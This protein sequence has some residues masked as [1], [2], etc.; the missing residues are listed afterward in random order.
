MYIKIYVYKKNTKSLDQTQRER[1]ENTME[2]LTMALLGWW[3]WW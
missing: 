3:W 2:A 1:Q